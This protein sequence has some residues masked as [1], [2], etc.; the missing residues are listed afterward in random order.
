MIKPMPGGDCGVRR[1]LPPPRQWVAL[2]GDALYRYALA[3][4][5]RSHEAEEAVQETFLAALA[6]RAQFGGRSDPLTWL[7]GILRHK[8]AGRLRS[9]AR[10]GTRAAGDELAAF[11]DGSGHWRG[12][13]V[14]WT[15]PAD[16][17]ERADFWRVVR[18]CLAELPGAMAAAF[19]LRTLDECPAEEVC[20]RLAVSP[21]NLYV[22]LH[23]AR[24]RLLRCLQ[25]HWFN[26]EE[27]PC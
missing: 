20:A 16:L 4:L 15:D 27:R 13:T 22:L 8:V 3:R 26:T 14:R 1:E 9:E 12:P 10:R 25:L 11:F 19:T 23:R 24:L 6:V 17:A 2:Y 18:S 21:A 7:T 5:R